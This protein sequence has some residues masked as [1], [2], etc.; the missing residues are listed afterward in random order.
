AEPR[1][2]AGTSQSS[3]GNFEVPVSPLDPGVPLGDLI[4]PTELVFTP[5]SFKEVFTLLDTQPEAGTVSVQLDDDA[6]AGGNPGG[7][8]DDPDSVNAT[9]FLP[10]SG[11]DG[12]LTW[13]LSNTGAPS[14]FT[15]VDGP[16]GSILVQQVQG[17]NT[18]TVLTITIDPADG[19]YSVVQNAAILHPAG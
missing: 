9:G 16:N 19:S 6:K 15:Y 1:P 3:G 11:G 7:V 4:P 17:G 12:V 10:G 5:P 13:D 8:G 18:V 14:G 2:A